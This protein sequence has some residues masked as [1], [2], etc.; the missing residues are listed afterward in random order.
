[1][2]GDNTGS[3]S[4]WNRDARAA[5]RLAI[6]ETAING[7][8]MQS[9]DP[10]RVRLSITTQLD[11]MCG[12]NPPAEMNEITTEIAAGAEE[13]AKLFLRVCDLAATQRR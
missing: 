3:A 9:A 13:V 6:I 1:M 4:E 12:R 2:P 7:L 10:D 5:G 8:I 11:V